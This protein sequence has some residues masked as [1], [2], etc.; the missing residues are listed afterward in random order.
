M[1]MLSQHEDF[2]P[3]VGRRFSFEG[4]PATLRLATIDVKPIASAADRAPFIL[5]FHGPADVVM[6]EGLHRAH[7]EDGP[8]TELYVMPIHTAGRDRQDYQAVF[9]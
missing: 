2:A 3:Y 1:T 7:I 5:V 4:Q 8:V 9:N 6:P